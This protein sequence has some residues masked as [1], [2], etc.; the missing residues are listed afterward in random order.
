MMADTTI[1]SWITAEVDQALERVRR[2]LAA[3]AAAPQDA[4][5]LLTCPEHLHQVSG[6]LN[7]VGL[8]GATRFCEALETSLPKLNGSGAQVAALLDRAVLELKQFVDD[9]ARGE[10]NVPVRLYR[11]YRE[12]AELQG[13]ADSSESELFFPDLTPPAP[14]HPRPHALD[15]ADV[16]AFLQS[17]R[18]RW[19]RG[20]LA[21]IRR[22]PKG[23]DDM[24]ETLDAIHSVSH[25]LP[26]RRAPWWVAGG[27]VD[28]LL[29]VC[30]PERL[31][32]ARVLW[33]KLDRQ[34]RELA[35]RSPSDNEPV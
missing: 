3:Y 30:E 9:V 21:W 35:A 20:I 11:A 23:L 8:S 1:L 16:P 13:R 26:E 33:N 29:D 6:A 28:A 2:Q 4:S 18:T 27:V 19:Q 10:P 12:L 25:L 31:A 5:V 14:S 15:E 7:M 34:M 22:Q 32:R 17:Q 24:G